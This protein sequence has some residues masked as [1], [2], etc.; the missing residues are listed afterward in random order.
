MTRP[1]AKTKKYAQEASLVCHSL[2]QTSPHFF[3]LTQVALLY[4][5][6]SGQH[7]TNAGFEFVLGPKAVESEWLS[8]LGSQLI[9][10]VY[11][12]MPQRLARRLSA[13]FQDK[14]S[15]GQVGVVYK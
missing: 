5:I 11:R 14:E 13:G 1:T 10:Q 4:E 7:R 12:R 2:A 9:P 3:F 8:M 6:L 15:K